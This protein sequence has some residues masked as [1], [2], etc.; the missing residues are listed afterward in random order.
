[1]VTFNKLLWKEWQE[2]EKSDRRK[3]GGREGEMNAPKSAQPDIFLI[4]PLKEL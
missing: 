1:M 3:E 4:T 2:K